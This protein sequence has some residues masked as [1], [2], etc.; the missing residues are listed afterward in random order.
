[1]QS[2]HAQRILASER[3]S[4]PHAVATFDD[5]VATPQRKLLSE[6]QQDRLDDLVKDL[7]GLD[8]TAAASITQRAGRIGLSSSTHNNI[9]YW[10]FAASKSPETA[11]LV[12]WCVIPC[13]L[14]LC[15]V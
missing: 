4:A 2:A 10:H 11:P 7:P 8:P 14:V 15:Y 9:F 6:T 13:C 1:M 12:I 3:P 5:A